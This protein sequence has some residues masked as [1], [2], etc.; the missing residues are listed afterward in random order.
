MIA[1]NRKKDEWYRLQR[2]PEVFLKLFSRI[3][4]IPFKY[5]LFILYLLLLYL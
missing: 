4:L 3:N 5:H 1:N 2:E